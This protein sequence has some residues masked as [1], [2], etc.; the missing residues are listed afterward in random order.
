M[1]VISVFRHHAMEHWVSGIFRHL[2]Q[3][4]GVNQA[5]IA[6]VEGEL[7]Q[8]GISFRHICKIVKSDYVCRSVC[9]S[10]WNNSAPT[11]RIFVKF[12]IWV[13]FENLSRKYKFHWNITITIIITVCLQ[14]LY[15]KTN[16]HFLSY[17]T[18]FFVEWGMF[19]T[20]VVE[21]IKTQF[22]L[23][24]LKKLCCWWDNV[25]KYLELNRPHMTVWCMHIACWIPETTHTHTHTHV[26]RRIFAF[27]LQEWLHE[28]ASLLCCT[29][30]AV[31][32]N[33][34]ETKMSLQLSFIFLVPY[35]SGCFNVIPVTR[36]L[37][38]GMIKPRERVQGSLLELWGLFSRF[39]SSRHCLT[40]FTVLLWVL[41]LSISSESWQNRCVTSDST[42]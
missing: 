6:T 30:I 32:A 2:H 19:R 15:M 3:Y 37:C 39:T 4:F 27:L 26:I 40:L 13:L 7:E 24:D 29:H 1:D 38:Q 18:I 8:I 41:L 10:T 22:M 31:L 35:N 5:V 42:L 20:G 17:L 36:S 11:G 21:K 25:E 12:Y 9:L 33:C 16:V 28:R 34:L 23:I 14:V